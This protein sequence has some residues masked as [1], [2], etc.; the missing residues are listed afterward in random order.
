[1]FLTDNPSAYSG[2]VVSDIVPLSGGI[3]LPKNSKNAA[4]PVTISVRTINSQSLKICACL[5]LI[6][7]SS[8]H[9]MDHD[10]VVFKINLLF[11]G[12]I[13]ENCVNSPQL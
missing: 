13:V 5:T 1:M 9:A 7:A 10:I 6:H 4:T 3:T 11:R 12:R 2:S 8:V